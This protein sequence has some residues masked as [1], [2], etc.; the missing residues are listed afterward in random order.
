MKKIFLLIITVLINSNIIYSQ[1]LLKLFENA[2][3]TT[4]VSSNY[5]MIGN[6]YQKNIEVKVWGQAIN[7]PG[8]YV[9]PEGMK[10][11]ELLTYAGGL[12]EKAKLDQIRII[13]M[14]NEALGIKEDRFIMIDY[15]DLVKADTTDFSQIKNLSLMP[16]DIIIIPSDDRWTFRDYALLS[17][18]VTTSILGFIYIVLN[19]AKIK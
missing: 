12:S 10:L 3:S 16:N 17:L 9:I 7:N 11:L 19:L 18:N 15:R 5:Y 4:K 2:E 6:K 14:K 8:I 1:D 13:R